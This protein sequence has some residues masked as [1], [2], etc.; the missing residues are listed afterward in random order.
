MRYGPDYQEEVVL[1]DGTRVRLR[2]V[3]P[4]DKE[5]LE[6]GLVR[7]SPQSQ[8]FRFFTAKVRFTESELA[9]LT[10][11]DG[12]D[13]FAIGALL[14]EPDGSEGAG[15][16]VGRF[17]RLLGEPDVAEPAIVV[18]D[19]HQKKG[20]GSILMQRLVEAGRERGIRRFRSEFLA[21]NTGIREL[22]RALAPQ[23][24]FRSSGSVVIADVPLE[25]EAPRPGASAARPEDRESI[26]AQLLKMV[27][28][29]TLEL[30]HRFQTLFD[31]S[32][33]LAA[34]RDREAAGPDE[35]TGDSG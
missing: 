12:D 30:R 23:V 16:A 2:L 14:L 35:R 19:E 28:E 9:Y 34:W 24:E 11:L 29:S 1:R 4:S 27:A 15:I 18:L 3:R 32:R 13:H 17:V 22:L 21:T 7:L 26:F 20:L 8:Y 31:P 10:E 25:L 33:L 5:H 6:R